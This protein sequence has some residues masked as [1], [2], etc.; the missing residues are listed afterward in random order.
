MKITV[1]MEELVENQS[2]EYLMSYD[3]GKTGNFD[4][5]LMHNKNKDLIGIAEYKQMGAAGK[6]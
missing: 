5:V 6:V 2:I 4:V 3:A 1:S